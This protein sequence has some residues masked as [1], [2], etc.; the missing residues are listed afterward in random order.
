VPEQQQIGGGCHHVEDQAYVYSQHQ[1]ASNMTSLLGLEDDVGIEFP[2]MD[3]SNVVG[4]AVAISG[5]VLISLA[6]NLQKLA[7]K[8]LK[9]ESQGI[10][11]DRPSGNA[12][13]GDELESLPEHARESDS[14]ESQ[15]TVVPLETDRLLSPSPS[16]DYSRPR[17][18]GLRAERRSE[19]PRPSLFSKLGLGWRK[20]E[21]PAAV[22]PVDI[23]TS[24]NERRYRATRGSAT[25]KKGAMTMDTGKESNYLKSKLWCVACPYE[26]SYLRN[27]SSSGGQDFYS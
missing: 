4:I 18:H 14:S 1:L 7:H 22:L 24:N 19:P 8:R 15:I 12:H 20:S 11:D 2:S 23:V 6:L 17:R 5:N 3:T 25:P 27:S 13:R 10:V 9:A 21:T 26:R 16:I